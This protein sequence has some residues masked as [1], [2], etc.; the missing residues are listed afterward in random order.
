VRERESL[1]G[2]RREIYTDRLSEREGGRGREGERLFRRE[3]KYL[4]CLNV[5]LGA[6]DPCT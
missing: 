5:A 6:T 1:R 3:R 4:V 2:G